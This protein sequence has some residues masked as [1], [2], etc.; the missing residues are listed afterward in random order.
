MPLG[1]FP[2]IHCIVPDIYRFQRS[3]F[4]QVVT[5]K[6][7]IAAKMSRIWRIISTHLVPNRYTFCYR[8]HPIPLIGP[9]DRLLN[10]IY[11]L[12]SPVKVENTVFIFLSM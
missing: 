3:L 6:V 11:V 8:S 4:G 7:E 5:I 2:L 10:F 9:A 12:F 1:F